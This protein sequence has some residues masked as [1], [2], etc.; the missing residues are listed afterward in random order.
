MG[1]KHLS[2]NS[3]CIA[4]EARK[5]LR[6]FQKLNRKTNVVVKRRNWREFWEPNH[7]KAQWDMVI[8]FGYDSRE[9]VERF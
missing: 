3:T 9:T 8:E 7:A 1:Q 6:V 2:G 5:N 4:L